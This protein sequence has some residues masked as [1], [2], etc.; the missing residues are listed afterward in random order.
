LEKEKQRADDIQNKID[1]VSGN[2]LKHN[3]NH[4]AKH[5]DKMKNKEAAKK[6]ALKPVDV[7][8]SDIIY[9]Y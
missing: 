3:M 4:I 5:R 6:P 9:E 2:P 8:F 1:A 7:I